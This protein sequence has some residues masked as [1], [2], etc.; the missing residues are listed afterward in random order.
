MTTETG[1]GTG[2][3]KRGKGAL[4]IVALLAILYAAASIHM[5]LAGLLFVCAL[6]LAALSII[7]PTP[8]YGLPTR[9]YGAAVFFSVLIGGSVAMGSV[10]GRHD[11]ER[12]AALKASSSDMKSSILWVICET[13]LL[14]RSRACS[15]LLLV[16]S[17]VRS[18]AIA[19]ASNPA[20]M[21]APCPRKP[22]QGVSRTRKSR[23]RKDGFGA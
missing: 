3:P 15:I 17:T 11:E 14:Q 10:A 18:C 7:R 12:L 16:T 22:Y 21:M 19:P 2:T 20:A 9:R 23:P 8:S 4:Q 1:T 13:S 6:L 5:A